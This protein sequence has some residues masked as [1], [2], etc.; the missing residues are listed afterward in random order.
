[1]L[2]L[3]FSRP[4]FVGGTLVTDVPDACS[5]VGIVTA[6]VDVTDQVAINGN[7]ASFVLRAMENC[8]CFTGWGS[9]TKGGRHDARFPWEVP[10]ADDNKCKTDVVRMSQGG[11]EPRANDLYDH[12]KTPTI[13]EKGCALTSLAMAINAAGLGFTPGQLNEEMKLTPGDYAGTLGR[14]GS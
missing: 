8:C 6:P 13:E 11:G 14:R 2:S 1:L 7:T 4:R 9:A 5:R 3:R 12:S 10:F